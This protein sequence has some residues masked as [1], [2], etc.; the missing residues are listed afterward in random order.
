MLT[1]HYLCCCVYIKEKEIPFPTTM[2]NYDNDDVAA[3]A[4]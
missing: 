4:T 2:C 1:C 3:G